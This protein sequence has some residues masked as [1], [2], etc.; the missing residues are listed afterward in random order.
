MSDHSLL[1]S[2]PMVLALLAEQKT[3]TRRLPSVTNCLVDGRR[4]KA[5]F[6]RL[7]FSSKSVFLDNGPS[8]AG[9]PGPYLHV[10]AK[11][12]N[13]THRVYP[14]YQ[15]GD[16]IWIKETHGIDHRVDP[17]TCGRGW[18]YY[19]AD[20]GGCP[21]TACDH[22]R[23]SIFMRK[24]HAR[25]RRVVAEVR[26]ERLQAITKAGVLAE[27]TPG[28]ELENASEDEAI[29]CYRKLWETINGKKSWKKNPWILVI[30]FEP[31]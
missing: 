24:E 29:A 25:I 7:N 13:T 20:E 17:K 19:V 27:G 2:A 3:E 28:F 26:I 30:R 22:L 10:P 1:M 6:D 11:D 4:S 21:R 5:M 15:P 16:T 9:N 8:P 14:V 31:T 18:V 23:P 12:G